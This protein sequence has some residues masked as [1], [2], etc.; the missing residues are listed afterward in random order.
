MKLTPVAPGEQG[1][2]S[3]GVRL[4]LRPPPDSD[5]NYGRLEAID[6]ENKKSVW[7]HRRRAS[8]TTGV[9]A[10]ADGIVFAGYV[11][12]TFSAF[13][14]A[15]ENVLWNTRL[16]EVPNSNATTYAVNGKQYIAVVAGN[17]GNH[18]RL[19]MRMMPE[20]KNPSNRSAAVFVFALRGKDVLQRQE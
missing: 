3:T 20:I 16:T 4:S 9:L 12:R 7:V 11:D 14:D 1:L 10:T 13:D 5:G 19:F 2:L 8:S 18:A 6:L 15:T 17:G